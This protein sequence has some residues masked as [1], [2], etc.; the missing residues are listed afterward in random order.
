MEIGGA[1][2]PSNGAGGVEDPRGPAGEAGILPQLMGSV[3]T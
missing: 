3:G 2:V 1:M